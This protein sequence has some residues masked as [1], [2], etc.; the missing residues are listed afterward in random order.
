[1]AI[2]NQKLEWHSVERLLPPRSLML[3]NC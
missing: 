1:M 3:Q 2:Y